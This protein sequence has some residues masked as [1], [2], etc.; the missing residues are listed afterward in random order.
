MSVIQ[1]ICSVSVASIFYMVIHVKQY[2]EL[3]RLWCS[4]TKACEL[5]IIILLHP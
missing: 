4:V 2:C 5:V 1:D 3:V